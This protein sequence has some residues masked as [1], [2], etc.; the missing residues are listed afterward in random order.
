MAANNRSHT[1]LLDHREKRTNTLFALPKTLGRSRH[2]DPVRASQRTASNHRH[3]TLPSEK[4][5]EADLRVRE[6]AECQRALKANDDILN[7][8]TKRP[9]ATISDA[10]I[11]ILILIVA[12]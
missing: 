2:G 10:A 8:A 1:P 4:E 3:S 6:N 5:L 11:Q 7:E 9:S 12:P